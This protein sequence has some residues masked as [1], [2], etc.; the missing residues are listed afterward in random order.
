MINTRK[1]TKF[2]LFKDRFWKILQY[3]FTRKPPTTENALLGFYTIQK[4]CKKKQAGSLV[5]EKQPSKLL[6]KLKHGRLK[7]GYFANPA[8][9]LLQSCLPGK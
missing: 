7:P 6:Q 2:R 5:K 3:S 4:E 1:Q 8:M 9:A